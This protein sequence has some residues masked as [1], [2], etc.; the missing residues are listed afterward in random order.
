MKVQVQREILKGK[1][2]RTSCS[3]EANFQVR[4][5]HSTAL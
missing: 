1:E 5:K 4:S 3:L 2:G